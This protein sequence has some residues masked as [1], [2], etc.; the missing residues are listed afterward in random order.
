MVAIDRETWAVAAR[1]R[2]VE[3]MQSI[4]GKRVKSVTFIQPRYLSWRRTRRELLVAW[5]Y[6]SRIWLR[7]TLLSVTVILAVGLAC[8]MLVPATRFPWKGLF[9]APLVTFLPIA[10]VLG[11]AVALPRTITLGHSNASVHQIWVT[12]RAQAAWITHIRIRPTTLGVHWLIVRYQNP[13]LGTRSIRAAIPAKVDRD[14]LD[15]AI[16]QLLASRDQA[17]AAQAKKADRT[18]GRGWFAPAR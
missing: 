17:I 2:G 1:R 5:P 9:L 11:L 13:R 16:A 4:S 7:A 12:R 3:V 15:A 10:L 18:I 6:L 8:E 14:R